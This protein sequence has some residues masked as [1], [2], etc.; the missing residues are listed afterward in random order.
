MSRVLRR[1]ETLK[2]WPQNLVTE[3]GLQAGQAHVLSKILEQNLD[4]NTAAGGGFLLVEMDHR[5]DMPADGIIADH[6]SKETSDIAQAICLVAVNRV[7]VFSK[8]S[9]KQVRPQAINLCESLSNQ[10]VELGVC[11]FLGATLDNH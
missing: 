3:T 11:S 5:K 1:E 2:A 4:E 6:V 10:S 7:V 8:G 9:L